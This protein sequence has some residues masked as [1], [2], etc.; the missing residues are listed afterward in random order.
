[1]VGALRH[2]KVCAGGMQAFYVLFRGFCRLFEGQCFNTHAPQHPQHASGH[3]D[4]QPHSFTSFSLCFM[5][6]TV[7]LASPAWAP[8]WLTHATELRALLL[9]W[10]QVL[11]WLAAAPSAIDGAIR[12]G[13]VFLTMH[14][15][16]DVATHNQALKQGKCVG[17][18]QGI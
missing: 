3:F 12:P 10:P 1:M 4:G 17:Q 7:T 9:C 5:N 18:G 13:C 16:L 6:I 11:S 15:M 8:S 2:V 14:L